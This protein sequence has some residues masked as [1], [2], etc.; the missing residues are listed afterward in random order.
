MKRNLTFLSALIAAGLFISGITLSTTVEAQMVAKERNQMMKMLGGNMKKLKQATDTATM[1]AAAKVINM[2]AK[3]LGDEKLW[4][5]GSGGGET[6]AKME[7]WQD[8]AGFKS[9]MK[10]LEN[11]SANLIKVAMGGNLGDSKKAFGAVGKTCGGCHK[12]FR[13]PKNK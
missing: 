3:K 7:I 2:N 4:P 1:V 9:K 12:P 10:D 11:A 13:A 8:M 5:K 6:R